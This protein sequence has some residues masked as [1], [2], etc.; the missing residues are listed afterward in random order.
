MLNLLMN[1]GYWLVDLKLV[2]FFLKEF[3]KVGE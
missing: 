1:L 3:M 2:K